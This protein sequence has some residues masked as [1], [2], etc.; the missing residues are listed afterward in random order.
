MKLSDG[1]ESRRSIRKYKDNPLTKEQIDELLYA[2]IL[3]P[4][5]KNKQPWRFL[6]VSG[7][8]KL[9]MINAMEAGVQKEIDGE[10]LLPESRGGLADALATIRIMKSA[11]VTIFVFD[12]EFT[13]PFE[14]IDSERHVTELVNTLSIG[15]A[16]E[17]MILKATEM[18]LGTLWIGNTFYAYRELQEFFETDMQLMAAVSVGYPDEEPQ[19]RPR[20]KL[21]DVTQYFLS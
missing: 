6:V 7:E 17:N 11:P 2:A 21:E 15:A 13:S 9:G 20:K 14:E 8:K 18:G 16:I 1:I 4:S 5:G 12:E 10:G 3:A 19:P